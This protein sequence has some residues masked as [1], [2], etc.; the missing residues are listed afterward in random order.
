MTIITIPDSQNYDTFQLSFNN[1]AGGSAPILYDFA[2]IPILIAIDSVVS[3]NNGVNVSMTQQAALLYAEYEFSIDAGL[4][5]TAVAEA[6]QLS[7][8]HVKVSITGLVNL[9]TY[10]GMLIR[11]RNID[12]YESE[13]LLIPI[14]TPSDSLRAPT[15]TNVTRSK[16][17]QTVDIS[18]TKNDLPGT[19]LPT[20]V[21]VVYTRKN[22]STST[23]TRTVTWDADGNAI[24]GQ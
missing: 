1:P 11:A 23:V 20:S 14:F 9:Q 10:I 18:Y 24:I 15:I 19:A 16:V 5:Y 2:P 13:P 17:F 21:V 3:K 6:I 22:G 12:N 4:T 7:N 8:N